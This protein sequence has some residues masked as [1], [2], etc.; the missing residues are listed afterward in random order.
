M[1]S[2]N[3][4]AEC[5]KDFRSGFHNLRQASHANCWKHSGEFL[6]CQE[7][8]LAVCDR[9]GWQATWTTRYGRNPHFLFEKK[10]Q[11][12]VSSLFGRRNF[13]NRIEACF[14]GKS[15]ASKAVQSPT[16]DISPNSHVCFTW[17]KQ[18][19]L[20]GRANLTRVTIATRWFI[21]RLQPSS[22]RCADHRPAV[23]IATHST[24][25]KCHSERS[26]ESPMNR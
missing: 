18:R 14:T 4:R 20:F 21:I 25:V 11:N 2:W 22:V 7:N 17:N 6:K 12:T 9:S 19:L 3:V 16:T 10:R 15:M 23:M 24:I 5:L 13:P 1:I 26:E 8:P